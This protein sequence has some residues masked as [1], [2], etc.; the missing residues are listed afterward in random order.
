MEGEGGREERGQGGRGKRGRRK[1]RVRG[2]PKVEK[3]GR[4]RKGKR[5]KGRKRKGNRKVG[6]E[7]GS[8]QKKLCFW[9]KKLQ[10]IVLQEQQGEQNK[11]GERVMERGRKA[12]ASKIRSM[13]EKGSLFLIPR[14][15]QDSHA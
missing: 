7:V 3:R 5:E 8:R 15:V 2:R 6:K 14:Y 9:K 12:K 11:N 13:H 1:E 10:F 4:K